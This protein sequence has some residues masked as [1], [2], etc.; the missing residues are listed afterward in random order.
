MDFYFYEKLKF[1][2]F[3]YHFAFF[4]Q[5]FTLYNIGIL[6]SRADIVY[7]KN[8]M[9]LVYYLYKMPFVSAF[10]VENGGRRCILSG[11]NLTF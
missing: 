1:G 7:G 8:A 10:L 11:R 2:K 4:S 9:F 3:I 5:I 6:F